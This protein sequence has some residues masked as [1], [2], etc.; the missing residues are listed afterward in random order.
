MV[1]EKKMIACFGDNVLQ[2]E[3][4]F[5]VTQTWYLIIMT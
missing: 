2:F 3:F 4:V 5:S 1:K